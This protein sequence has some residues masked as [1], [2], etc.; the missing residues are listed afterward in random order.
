[1]N[2]LKFLDL[3][4]DVLTFLNNSVV[5]TVSVEILDYSRWTTARDAGSIRQL[6]QTWSHDKNYSEL[7]FE[8]DY[9][10]EETG[11]GYVWVSTVPGQT[12]YRIRADA[13][14]GAA[15]KLIFDDARPSRPLKAGMVR[16]CFWSGRSLRDPTYC[17]RRVPYLKV[18]LCDFAS[19]GEVYQVVVDI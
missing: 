9:E 18:R 16:S 10:S 1:M 8:I 7:C 2:F 14:L 13:E 12:V 5:M 19:R 11:P 3:I 15:L 17:I 6:F 4:I